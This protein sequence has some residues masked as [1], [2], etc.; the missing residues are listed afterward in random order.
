MDGVRQY[1]R[2]FFE[3]GPEIITQ[4]FQLLARRAVGDAHRGAEQTVLA[5]GGVADV[6]GA[7]LGVL[8]R[9]DAV[10]QG[11]DAGGAEGDVLHCA[12]KAAQGDVVAYAEGTLNDHGGTGNQVGQGGLGTQRNGQSGNACTGDQAVD[13]AAQKIQHLNTAEQQDQS[14]VDLLKEA[15]HGLVGFQV[16]TVLGAAQKQAAQPRRV[17]QALRQQ[18][19]RGN[20]DN[21]TGRVPYGRGGVKGPREHQESKVPQQTAHKQ[22]GR[23]NKPVEQNLQPVRNFSLQLAAQLVKNPAEQPRTEQA[24]G[25]QDNGEKN[26]QQRRIVSETGQPGQKLIFGLCYFIHRKKT[27]PLHGW[28][29]A[30]DGQGSMN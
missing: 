28:T 6:L 26:P 18:T 10:V 13:F 29:S 14:A 16:Q 5:G 24:D 19:D 20:T 9:D 15:V 2:I 8:H 21:G 11:A 30:P 12:L 4:G 7:D 25:N 23:F 17:P 1:L 27:F 3:H 22:N